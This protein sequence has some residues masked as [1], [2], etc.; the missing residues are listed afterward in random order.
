MK[1]KSRIINWLKKPFYLKCK[2]LIIKFLSI[3]T[4]L[5][6]NIKLT[7]S[8]TYISYIPDSQV[9]FNSHPEFYYLVKKFT[10]NNNF[11]NYGD[12]PRLWF[13]I[14]NIKQTLLDGIE[15][16]FA[17]LGVWRGNTAAILAF[18]ASLNNKKLYLFD[19]FNGFSNDDLTGI[20]SDKEINFSDTSIELVK[21][22]IG[23]HNDSCI[24]IKGRF[25][26]SLL[27]ANVSRKYSIVSIDCDLYEP[28]KSGLEFFY[29]L[30]PI[31]GIIFLHDYSSKFWNGSQKAI[32][33]FCKEN[34]EY[35]ILLPDKSGSAC[36]RKSH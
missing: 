14:L 25:P 4:L 7:I 16:D 12:F 5:L 22:V 26:N 36:L 13:Y 29:P 15:G 9:Y 19:T 31:G 35:L 10:S 8:Y 32:D 30:M 6:N 3:V 33:E 21:N 18:Y 24:Y 20:D 1:F 28:I 27:S 23:E 34:N 11:N 2:I 17:E